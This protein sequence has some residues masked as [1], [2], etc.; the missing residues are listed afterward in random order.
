MSDIV[1]GSAETCAEGEVVANDRLAQ[2]LRVILTTNP[3][4]Y[5]D[6]TGKPVVCLPLGGCTQDRTPH[7]LRGD[8]ARATLFATIS[9]D[10]HFVPFQEEVNR[11]L[12]ILEDMAWKDIRMDVGYQSA[13]EQIDLIDALDILVNSVEGVVVYYGTCSGLR[14]RL[15]DVAIANGI[16]VRQEQWPKG[17][18]RLSQRI[19]ELR[20]LLEAGGIQVERGRSNGPRWIKVSRLPSSD[21]EL[22]RASVERPEAKSATSHT[23]GS[24]DDSD[25]SVA[26][27]LRSIE[28]P[29]PKDSP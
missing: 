24:D 20:H 3:E 17:A 23:L 22:A 2:A 1:A 7:R 28:A 29:S 26:A 5:I 19:W 13:V 27:L 14:D 4:L 9:R 25:G 10:A 15:N 8:R 6:L 12:W 16:D 21:G 18:S 11:I